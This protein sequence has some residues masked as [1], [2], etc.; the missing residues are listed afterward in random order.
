MTGFLTTLIFSLAL[1]TIWPR[2]VVESTTQ[3]PA[4]PKN[5]QTGVILVKLSAPIY[6]PAAR[7]ARISGDVDLM[8]IVRQDGS[9]GSVAVVSGSPMLTAAAVGSAQHTQFECRKCSE[10]ENRYRLVYTFQIEDTG[11]QRGTPRDYNG[12]DRLHLR[13]RARLQKESFAEMS[14]SMEMRFLTAAA[15]LGIICST[16]LRRP[17]VF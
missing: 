14:V 12:R 16:D 13:P 17:M 9:V 1:T 3:N 2:T 10:A 11:I 15:T 5:S 6:P 8:L 4:T 7:T